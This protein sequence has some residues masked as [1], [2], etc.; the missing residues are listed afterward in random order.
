MSEVSLKSNLSAYLC[1]LIVS[2]ICVGI[3]LLPQDLA[4]LFEYARPQI[5]Q[6]E[7]WRLVSGHLVHLGWHHLVMNLLGFWLIWHLF[8]SKENPL[9]YCIYRLPL[10]TI[11]TSLGLLLLSPEVVWYR[12]FSGILHGLLSLALLHQLRQQAVMN[13]LLLIL[14]AAKLVWEQT[15]GPLPGSEPWIDGRVIV[16]AHLYG[17]LCG[18]IL[19]LLER[20]YTLFSHR[21]VAG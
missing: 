16:D 17:A 1:P 20:S 7:W 9:A 5:L 8:L 14:L 18:V 13:T 12:G 15:T 6:G 21:E 2:V 4:D 3:A 10:L 19:W 11:G